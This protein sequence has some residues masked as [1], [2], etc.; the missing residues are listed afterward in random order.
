MYFKN[1]IILLLW[2]SMIP[3]WAPAQ[4]DNSWQMQAE[5]MV[6]TQIVSRGVADQRLLKVMRET[7]RHLFV[8]ES[9][10]N[11]A[12]QDGPLPIGH[13][14][15]ISQPYIVALMTELL[16]LKGDERVLEIGTGSGYQA[17]VLAQLVKSVYTIEIVEPLAKSSS[18][19]LK[20]LGHDNVIVKWGDGYKGWPEH[21]PFDRIIVT[22]APEEIPQALI[23]Q[24]AIGGRMVLPVGKHY[25]ELVLVT[26]NEK[27]VTRKDI[28]PVRFVPMVHPKDE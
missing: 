7:P 18:V 11:Q 26:K 6:K 27:K 4:I 24:L 8:P 13:Q 12:Y 22:A 23:D 16:Q 28:I 3:A 5:K 19:L 21:A 2:I 17:A 20:K 25:Q 14:Q 15:T 1:S 10:S 9:Y